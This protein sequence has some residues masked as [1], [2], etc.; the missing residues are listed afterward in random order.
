MLARIEE[1]SPTPNAATKFRSLS[2]WEN[3]LK[4]VRRE[5]VEYPASERA[6]K[7][8]ANAPKS[9]IRAEL[10]GG[11]FCLWECL[12][13]TK[14]PPTPGRGRILFFEDIGE[15]FYRLDRMM[16]RLVQSGVLL[17]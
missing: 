3:I 17:K 6:V 1:R 7:F 12:V 14:H 2:E 13:G 8:L 4:L 9:P 16:T 5:M 11:N 10:V 15:P